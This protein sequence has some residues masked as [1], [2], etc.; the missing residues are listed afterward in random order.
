[1]HQ[2]MTEIDSEE[3][4]GEEDVSGTTRDDS[5]MWDNAGDRDKWAEV[6]VES[7]SDESLVTSL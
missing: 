4:K 2:D 5:E 7:D 3:E 1:M 6:D